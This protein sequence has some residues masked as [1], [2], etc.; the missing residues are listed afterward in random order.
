MACVVVVW[1][2]IFEVLREGPTSTNAALMPKQAG[3]RNRVLVI[4]PHSS[5]RT[6]AFLNAANKLG[7]D[8]LFASEGQHSVV[9]VYADGLHIDLHDAGGALQT[10]IQEAKRRPFSG[11]I[12]TDDPTTE[13]AA[14]AAEKLKLPHNP[15]SAVKVARRKDLA[16]ALLREKGIPVPNHCLVDLRRA[17]APQAD[18]VRFP[19][20]L[21]P[22]A[23]SASRG[24]I[25]ADDHTQ[26]IH[27]CK[28]IDRLLQSEQA[29][30]RDTILAEDFIPG[31]E[32]A[33]E[34]MLTGGELN[35]LAVFD[36]P[37]PLDGP[38]F[39]ETYY[40]T[41]SRLS[42]DTLKKI[43]QRIDE[44]CAAYG[45]REGPIHAECRVNDQDVWIL[46]VAARTIGG[47]CGRLL[48]FGT[49]QSLEE[50]VLAHAMGLPFVSTRGEKEGAGV[51]MIPTPT[52]GILR[53]VEGSLAAE[54]VP[55]IEEVSIL[56]RPGYRLVPWPEGSSYL[57]FIF[58]RAPTPEQAE[59]ALRQAHACLNFV[60]APVWDLKPATGKTAE[61]V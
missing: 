28:R 34:G 3:V 42:K 2:E 50:L 9:S 36:K 49:G 23:L 59:S 33:V 31:I 15:L 21:K 51:L 5:Y 48:S 27:A 1:V 35:V 47:L 43:E 55:F 6:P 4:A 14:L 8:V 41:P 17:L 57:G 13:M 38:Y 52:A 12:G 16:R 37:D 60:V 7:V 24:V 40:V 26:F 53:R 18:K 44:S 25:R 29:K 10:I 30:E 19:C 20:V 39:E 22:L 32:V 11:I 56:V 54:R 46:E 45:L 58:A 61:A